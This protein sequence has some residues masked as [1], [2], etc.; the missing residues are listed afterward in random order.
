MSRAARQIA[1]GS[2]RSIGRHAVDR[3]REDA[4]HFEARL[5]RFAEKKTTLAETAD[6][7][8]VAVAH[9]RA[10]LR[11]RR[12]VRSRAAVE[13]CADVVARTGEAASAV[14]VVALVDE[15][16]RRA[17]R[18]LLTCGQRGALRVRFADYMSEFVR[19]FEKHP[20]VACRRKFVLRTVDRRI[21][22]GNGRRD[23]AA[24]SAERVGA[25]VAVRVS[26]AIAARS[27]RPAR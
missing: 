7:D 10:E 27:S 2:D 3:R 24:R 17:V 21:R 6:E 8:V 23:G 16:A 14:G 19:E 9:D 25:V 20:E 13:A 11:W 4:K 15:A 12:A 26:G 22:I 5:T 18:R 1:S